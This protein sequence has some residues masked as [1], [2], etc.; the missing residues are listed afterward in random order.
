MRLELWG[1]RIRVCCASRRGPATGSRTYAAAGALKPDPLLA[2]AEAAEGIA[3]HV[4]RVHPARDPAERSGR[5]AQ[6]LGP[7]LEVLR[8]AG[9]VSLQGARAGLQV[10]AVPRLGDGGRLLIPDARSRTAGDG[11]SQR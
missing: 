11:R 10:L 1:I 6:L 9:E 2:D 7:Q 3:Q 5:A 4:L 8:C